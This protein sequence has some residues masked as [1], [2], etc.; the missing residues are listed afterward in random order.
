M[1]NRQQNN[2]FKTY[3]FKFLKK[4]FKIT[5]KMENKIKYKNYHQITILIKINKK[6][7]QTQS[8]NYKKNNKTNKLIYQ[9][10]LLIQIKIIIQKKKKLQQIIKLFILYQKMK[11]IVFNKINYKKKKKKTSKK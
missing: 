11:I 4:Q 5:I 10:F 9:K 2:N 1:D 8:N 6:S 7:K 3:N